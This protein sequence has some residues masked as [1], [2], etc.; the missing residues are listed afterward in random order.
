MMAISPWTGDMTGGERVGFETI[1]GEVVERTEVV[2]DLDDEDLE[3][4]ASDPGWSYSTWIVW[5]CFF[6]LDEPCVLVSAL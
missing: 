6:C 1:L 3:G 5:R 2:L 4:V